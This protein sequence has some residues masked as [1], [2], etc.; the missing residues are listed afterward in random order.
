MAEMCVRKEYSGEAG[1][2]TRQRKKERVLYMYGT[3]GVWESVGRSEV[4]CH[5]DDDCSSACERARTEQ[6]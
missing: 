5:V 4:K 3:G 6:N 1:A 2:A